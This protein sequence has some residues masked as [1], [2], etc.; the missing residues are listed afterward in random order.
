[1]VDDGGRSEV[2]SRHIRP[3]GS[4]FAI[5]LLVIVYVSMVIAIKD[6]ANGN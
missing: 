3:S 6:Q 5:G 4:G 2:V 1:M